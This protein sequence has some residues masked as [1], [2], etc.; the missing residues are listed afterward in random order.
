MGARALAPFR[1]SR[2]PN[3]PPRQSRGEPPHLEAANRPPELLAVCSA[4][5]P[6]PDVGFLGK[7]E[8]NKNK[9]KTT[10]ASAPS[11]ASREGFWASPSL[12]RHR[13]VPQKVGQNPA[14]EVEDV[15]LLSICVIKKNPPALAGVW[16]RDAHKNASRRTLNDNRSKRLRCEFKQTH[17]RTHP[18]L[19][20]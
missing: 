5:S 17:A 7:R 3:Q 15:T 11:S 13:L 18:A 12:R 10:T 9:P 4:N 1:A 16:S 2:C 6:H 19:L 20:P 14:L 8:K